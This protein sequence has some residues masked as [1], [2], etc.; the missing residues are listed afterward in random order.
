[1]GEHF[2]NALIRIALGKSPK[3]K[4]EHRFSAYQFNRMSISS[5]SYEEIPSGIPCKFVTA[6]IDWIV[7]QLFIFLSDDRM[8]SQNT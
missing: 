6:L 8:A 2:P 7:G 4:N 1:M 3:T 5:S